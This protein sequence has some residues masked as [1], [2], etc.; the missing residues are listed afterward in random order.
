MIGALTAVAPSIGLADRPR[1]PAVGHAP[2]LAD[3]HPRRHGR[4]LRVRRA[5]RP[6][7]DPRP[8][9]DRR[10]RPARTRRGLRRLLRG[11]PLRR[12]F[13]HAHR[14]RLPPLSGGRLS[15]GGHG[16]VRGGLRARSWPSSPGFTPLVEP[17]SIDEAFLDVTASRAL[18]GDG[19]PSRARSRRRS[20]PR[21]DLP[22]SVGVASN[23]F[24]AKVA[25]DLEKPDGLVVV[26]PGARGGV[27]GAAAGLAPLGRGQG[28]GR[29]AR[30]H[31][32]SHH[33]PA[34]ADVPAA[35]LRGPLRQAR[36]RSRSSWP[37]ASTTASSSPDARAQVDGRRGDLRAGHARRRAPAGDPA[38]AERAGR[39]GA[40]G[41]GLCGPDG[42]AQAPLRRLFH[43]HP[44]PH[45]RSDARTASSSSA[46]G[47]CSSPRALAQAVRLIGVSVSG[48]GPA[49][50]GQLS[51]LEPDALRRE[52]LARAVDRLAARFGEKAVRPASLMGKPAARPGSAAG[53]ARSLTLPRAIPILASLLHR[54]THPLRRTPAANRG[55]SPIRLRALAVG[56]LVVD[57]QQGRRHLMRRHAALADLR[58]SLLMLK[59]VRTGILTLVAVIFAAE[60]LAAQSR[61]PGV[62]DT[63][64]VIGL[65]APMSGPAAIYGNLAVAKE[66]WARYVNDLGRGERAQAQGRAQGRR[67]QPGRAVANLRE[68]KD[69]VFLT[70]GLVGSAV[71]NAAKDEIAE[72]APAAGQCLCQPPASG[73]GSRGTSSSTSSSTTPTTPTRRST[74]SRTRST[75]LGAQEAGRLLPER[76]L[77]QGG[78][79]RRQPGHEGARR[80][81]NPRRRRALRSLRPR[82]RRRKRSS[83]RSRAPTRCSSPRSTRTRRASCA[84][85]PRSA[86]DPASSGPSASAT[87]QAMYRLLGE[88]WEGAYYSGSIGAVPGEPE[89]KA[90]LDIL[91]K[92]EPRLEGREGTALHRRRKHDHRRGGTQ[93]GRPQPDA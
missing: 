35:H 64:I 31:G 10:R 89:A 88:L 47:R 6:S 40:P 52:R 29:R 43:H 93:E 81:G 28:D 45:G 79:R 11:A 42:D 37:A 23:K 39:A 82:V 34:R 14:P 77:G 83:S 67:L 50:E 59:L 19:R 85:W 2:S 54:S 55:G 57:R 65:T 22:A 58:A 51:L 15:A 70:L 63:E 68:M 24:V 73:R 21:V 3:H 32:H 92:Y 87:H 69:S 9:R 26:P 86:T 66:A 41:P 90:V 84:R 5:A 33:R 60:P 80:E 91:I 4:V 7:G 44:R 25:S 30:G 16:Q 62:T 12:P 72:A 71:V 1:S 17:L 20:G 18:H 49:G 8:A 46:G 48:L 56:L 75:S 27:P 74:S 76:R 38:R 78:H 53:G 13:R 36:A 61:V